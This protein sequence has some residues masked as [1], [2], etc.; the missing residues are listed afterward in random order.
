MK[1]TV[2]LCILFELLA[3]R[4]L[5][6]SYLAE[7]HEI[8]E[9]TVY[10]YVDILSSNVPV[11]VKRG[12]DGGIFISDHYKLPVGFMTAAEY[13]AA[14]EALTLAY[15]HTLDERFLKAKRKLAAKTKAE[16]RDS[17]ISGSVESILI[18]G[19]AWG[20]TRAVSE[21]LRLIAECLKDKRILEL[22]YR[23]A[24]GEKARKRVEPHV[25]I[26]RRGAWLLYAFCHAC[27]DF[28]F[29]RVGRM[30]SLNRSA[31]RFRNRPFSHDNVRVSARAQNEETFVRL[32][33]TQE[34]YTAAQDWLGA[35]ALYEKEG[36]WY[37]DAYL[38]S[39]GEL[40]KRLLRFGADV[41][42]IEP[43]ILRERI[44]QTARKIVETYE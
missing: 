27:R 21:K 13:D 9:R 34:G 25:L 35:D 38:R 4:R 6:A 44:V 43:L 11:Y 15:S 7:K 42:V 5:T 26:F 17:A 29:F 10:R 2:L 36:V 41:K 31:E 33:F 14:I 28:R 19:G 8:S 30:L 22:E 18:D 20:D 40:I 24:T 37:A 39:D 32:A 3:K 1:F 16:T 23:E 12:R